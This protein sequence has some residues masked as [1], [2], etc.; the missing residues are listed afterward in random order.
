MA[1][2]QIEQWYEEAIAKWK[3]EAE[4]ATTP[5]ERERRLNEAKRY[6]KLLRDRIMPES[7]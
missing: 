6:E 1:A 5:K 4:F 2:S 7:D 3:R